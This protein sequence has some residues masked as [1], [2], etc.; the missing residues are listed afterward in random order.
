[1]LFSG[2]S[3]VNIP[4]VPPNNTHVRHRPPAAGQA[5]ALVPAAR[6]PFVPFK[7]R[8]FCTQSQRQQ[9]TNKLLGLYLTALL[10]E[11]QVPPAKQ[12]QVG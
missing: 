6:R 8:S 3:S 9:V 5:L 1:M 12:P 7:S 10:K 2:A 11:L 4:R